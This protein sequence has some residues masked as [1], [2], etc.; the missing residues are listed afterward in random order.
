[1]RK[2]VDSVFVLENQLKFQRFCIAAAGLPDFSRC[3]LPKA[4]KI[5][6]PNQHTM[7]QMAIKYTIW[8]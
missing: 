3:N 7:Y 6:V 5:P 2:T 1:M 4:G 8:S